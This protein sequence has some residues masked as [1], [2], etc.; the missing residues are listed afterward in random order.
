MKVVIPGGTGQ[1]GVILTRAFR[2]RGDDVVVVSRGGWSDAR[3]VNWDGRT[4]GPWAQEI[5]GADVVINL[6]GRSVSCRYT[7]ANL[8]S[9][10]DSRVDSTRV[11]GAA[12][13][14]ASRPPSVWLQMSTA[15]IYAHRFD[16]PNDESTGIIGGEEPGVPGYWSFS[17]EIAKAWEHAQQAAH[18]PRTRRVALRSSMVMS[19]DRGGIFDILLGL[20]H[21]GLG[22]PIAGGRQFV[23][24]IQ[25]VDFARAVEFLIAREDI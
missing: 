22:G 5:D 11:I 17:V 24:W 7:D 18:T 14:N 23:S 9:M 10:M 13:E 21:V 19:P 4:L 25:D 6:A 15:T 3:R 12:I 2:D 16:G 1:I 8:K 20:T